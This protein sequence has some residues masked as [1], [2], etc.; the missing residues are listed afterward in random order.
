MLLDIYSEGLGLS[1]LT[2]ATHTHTPRGTAPLFP[3]N[4][5][6]DSGAGGFLWMLRDTVLG[7]QAMGLPIAR[8]VSHYR[9]RPFTL[10][11]VIAR[12]ITHFLS[13]TIH[14]D[15]LPRVVWG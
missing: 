5:D 7:S 4:W 14:Y 12:P 8:S 15:G 3:K 2:M 13:Q 10:R 9:H 6:W 1:P 11:I